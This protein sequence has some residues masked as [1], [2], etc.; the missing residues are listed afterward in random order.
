MAIFMSH[1]AGGGMERSMLNIAKGMMAHGHQVD[2]L[3]TVARGPFARNLPQGMRV[4]EFARKRKLKMRYVGVVLSL[5]RYMREEK[6]HAIYSALGPQNVQLLLASKLARSD[7]RC[8]ISARGS[9]TA[10]ERQLGL[11]RRAHARAYKVLYPSADAI[12]AVSEGVRRHL[13]EDLGIPDSLIK[14]VYNPVD[15]EEIVRMSREPVAEPWLDGNSVPVILAAGRLFPEKGLDLLL[16]AFRLVLDRRQARLV[17]LGEGVLRDSLTEQVERLGLGGK[18]RMPG[19]VDNPFAYMARAHLFVLS[20][21]REG[22]GNVLV[23]ALACGCPVVSTDCPGGPRE[24]LEDGRWGTLT[25]TG[26]REALARAIQ[27]ALD[28]NADRRRLLERARFFSVERATA[29]YLSLLP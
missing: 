15:S 26:D 22:F 29:G 10:E 13:V 5:V 23:E 6:P 20:S 17:I 9:L 14:V 16:D 27:E 8:V 18:V 2:L 19:F 7:C 21:R 24:I 3:V 1:L 28:K 25:P 11:Y 12:I 4:F